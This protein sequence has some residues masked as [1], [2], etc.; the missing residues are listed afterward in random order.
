MIEV[1]PTIQLEE[2]EIELTFVRSPGPGGQNVNKVATAAQLRFDVQGSPSLPEDV[3][4]RM[5]RLAGKRVTS[6]GMLII[7]SHQYRTQELNRQAAVQRLIR[8]IQEASQP[9]RPRHKTRPSHAAVQRRLESK[10]KRS[11]LKRL[12]RQKDISG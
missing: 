7:E 10:H 12:R 9:P 8:L 4:E 11:E 2:G 3:R 5:L 6:E 1:T